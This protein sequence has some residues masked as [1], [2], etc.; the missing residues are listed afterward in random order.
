[1]YETSLR[2]YGGELVD[3]VRKL[4]LDVRHGDEAAEQ[5]LR[6]MRNILSFC[7]STATW[8]STQFRRGSTSS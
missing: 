4:L 1:M 7:R 5:E 2:I 6:A 8:V 3:R